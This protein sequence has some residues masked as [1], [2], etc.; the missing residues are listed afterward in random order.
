MCD[1]IIYDNIILLYTNQGGDF[2]THTR[3]HVYI[4]FGVRKN[5]V[6]THSYNYYY[7]FTIIIMYIIILLRG[8]IRVKTTTAV[9]MTAGTSLDDYGLDSVKSFRD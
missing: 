8:R 2:Y 9:A 7:I 3:T 4:V 6:I 1:L 5:H